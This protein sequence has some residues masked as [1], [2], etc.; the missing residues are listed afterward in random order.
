MFQSLKVRLF[1]FSCIL[2]GVNS[3]VYTQYIAANYYEHIVEY[4]NL[5]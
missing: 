2:Y 3:I 1:V 5:M 4:N